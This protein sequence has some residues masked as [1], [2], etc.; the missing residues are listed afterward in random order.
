MSWIVGALTAASTLASLFLGQISV[1]G[2]FL[3]VLLASA[4][5]MTLRV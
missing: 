1:G 2:E 4:V 3:G 5:L